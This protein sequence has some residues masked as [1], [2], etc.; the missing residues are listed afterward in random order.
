[1]FCAMI[2]FVFVKERQGEEPAEELQI[3]QREKQKRQS[4]PVV[5]A[6][7]AYVNVDQYWTF[8]TV[9]RH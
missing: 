5:A 6:A 1:M 7:A 2:C 8:K 3:H 4:R 9:Q